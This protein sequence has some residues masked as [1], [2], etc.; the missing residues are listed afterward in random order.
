MNVSCWCES[1]WLLAVD[2]GMYNGRALQRAHWSTRLLGNYNVCTYV[3]TYL[4]LWGNNA[5]R[6]RW[7]ANDRSIADLPIAV[8]LTE[9]RGTW[10]IGSEKKKTEWLA[11]NY[12]GHHMIAAYSNDTRATE[13]TQRT[14]RTLSITQVDLI[15]K[16]FSHIRFLFAS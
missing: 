5:R 9:N 11:D 4:L 12:A 13:L 14:Q 6:G 7:W 10:R 1:G 16:L 15:R 3:D 2:D 8:R